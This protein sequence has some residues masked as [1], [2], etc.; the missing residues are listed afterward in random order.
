MSAA[1]SCKNSLYFQNHKRLLKCPFCGYKMSWY[2]IFA[3]DTT[4]KYWYC[5]KCGCQV[6]DKERYSKSELSAIRKRYKA[7][8]KED[9][10]KLEKQL[11]KRR[12]ALSLWG[13]FM[14]EKKKVELLAEELQ[15]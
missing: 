7:S 11:E 14:S 13:K 5:T 10:E 6:P 3:Y 4:L 2:V 8:L 15:T 9:I 1:D 12:E